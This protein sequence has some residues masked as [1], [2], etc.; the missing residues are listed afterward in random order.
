MI[1]PVLPDEVTVIICEQK[2]KCIA[3][4][5]A[6][7]ENNVARKLGLNKADTHTQIGTAGPSLMQT[8]GKQ[9]PILHCA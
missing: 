9:R 6:T 7:I 2:I 4:S 1:Q 3:D 8:E 5:G